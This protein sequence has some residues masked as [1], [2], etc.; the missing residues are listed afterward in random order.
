VEVGKGKEWVD[1]NGKGKKEIVGERCVA[2]SGDD[3]SSEGSGG[4]ESGVDDTDD[5]RND[6]SCVAFGVSFS[7][8]DERGIFCGLWGVRKA[9]LLKGRIFWRCT[10][11]IELPLFQL[12]IWRCVLE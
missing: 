10:L 8:D 7:G 3:G 4:W 9:G 5:E 1:K 12:F 6:L 2:E 11:D